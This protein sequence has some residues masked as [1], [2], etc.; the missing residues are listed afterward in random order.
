MKRNKILASLLALSL[1]I[2]LAVPAF[3][4]GDTKVNGN[5]HEITISTITVMPTIEVYVG[6]P[7]TLIVN[8]YK[9]SYSNPS[10]NITNDTSSL[11]SVPTVIISKSTIGMTVTAK[12]TGTVAGNVKLAT[13]SNE[14]SNATSPSVFMFL[15]LISLTSSNVDTT[16]TPGSTTILTSGANAPTWA[17]TTAADQTT[18]VVTAAGDN[19]ATLDLAAG[20][21]SNPQYA[22]FKII[23]E[24]G[25]TAWA[26]G[27]SVTVKVVLTFTPKLGTGTAT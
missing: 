22:G 26:T 10:Y 1:C 15:N 11:M 5:E 27:D 19:A 24:S 2:G 4:A 18:A 13:S 14:V 7:P 12:P 20:D 3:A 21:S 23:G 9:M 17:T 25:G 8:P 16:T 6:T